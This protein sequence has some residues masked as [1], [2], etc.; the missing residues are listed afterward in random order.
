MTPRTSLRRLS[1]DSPDLVALVGGPHDAIELERQ[2]RQGLADAVVQVAGDA[3]AL[4]VRAD[5]AQPV[6]PAGVVD[7]EGGGLDEAV[8][9]LEVACREGVVLGALDRD[10]PDQGA[11]GPQRRV[12]ARA[13]ARRQA[14]PTGLEQVRL[15]HAGRDAP[16]PGAGE[17]GD[18]WVGERSGH[19]S[20]R[21]GGR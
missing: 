20:R 5:G 4:L 1:S 10:Q 3:G 6:E 8:Q 13:G 15:V 21:R 16:W 2:V 14:R 12:D 19:A 18:R 17:A 7:G 11:P 9:E